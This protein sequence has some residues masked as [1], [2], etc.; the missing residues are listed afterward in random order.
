MQ[1]V[2]CNPLCGTCKDLGMT[3]KHLIQVKPITAVQTH[4]MVEKEHR[5]K[6]SEV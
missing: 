3:G 4:T 6:K 5:Q 2:I 1:S